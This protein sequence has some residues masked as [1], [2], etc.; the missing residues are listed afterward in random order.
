MEGRL[1]GQIMDTITSFAISYLLGKALDTALSKLLY[2][3]A[4]S[5]AQILEDEIRKGRMRVSEIPE[6]D[7]AAMVFRYM[8]AAE[9]GAARRNLRLLAQIA[10]NLEPKEEFYGNEFL[11]WSAVIES[12]NRQE[13]NILGVMHRLA[14]ARD[15]PADTSGELWNSVVESTC[16]EFNMEEVE[17][18]AVCAALLRTGLLRTFSG[19]G[20]TGGQAFNPTPALKNLAELASIE[21]AY[22]ETALGSS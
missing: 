2:E 22:M 4:S 8:R 18:T 10:V 16:R 13:L 5:A 3:R 19:L 17:V 21:A 9:E 15:Y 1:A 20:L 12:L 6:S 11:R 7:A 14:K